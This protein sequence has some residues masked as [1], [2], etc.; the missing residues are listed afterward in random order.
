MPNS[1]QRYEELIE[2]LK[3]QKKESIESAAELITGDMRDSLGEDS[4]VDNHP[5]D[6]GTELYQRSRD[7]AAHDRLMHRVEAIDAAL[8]RYEKGEYGI[9]EH[10]GKKI[11]YERLELIPYTTVCTNCSREEEKEE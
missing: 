5:A 1:Y 6:I 10:C 7:I 3:T 9:C 8:K 2:T 11:P 4:L